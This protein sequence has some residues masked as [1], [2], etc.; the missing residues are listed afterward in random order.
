MIQ[1]DD[2]VMGF[3]ED[4]CLYCTERPDRIRIEYGRHSLEPH[5]IRDI[6]NRRME[7]WEIAYNA[8]K[9]LYESRNTARQQSPQPA[10]I[11]SSLLAHLLR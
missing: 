8:M 5:E 6:I 11:L 10:D 3:I 2:Q 7:Q 4:L 9:E 1:P